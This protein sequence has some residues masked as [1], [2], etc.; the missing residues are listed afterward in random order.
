[1]SSDLERLLREAG[2]R[3]PEP[4]PGVTSRARTLALRAVRRRS[5][6]RPAAL[7]LAAALVG[8]GV[9]IGA[10]IAPSGTAAPGVVGLGFLPERGWSVLQNGGDGTPV[11]P[12]IAIAANVELSPDDDPDGLPL[13][14]LETLAPE[15]VVIVASFIARGEQEYY[16]RLFPETSLPLRAGHASRGIE[17]GADVRPGRPLGQYQLRASVNGHN[18][19]VNFYFGSD[20]PTAAMLA[21]AQ[22][23]LDL[24]VVRP[25][26]VRYR[27]TTEAAEE[28]VDRTYACTNT[29][30]AG[31]R[32][33]AIIGTRGF[34][35]GATWKWPASVE[36]LND[37]G[38]IT[39]LARVT[40]PNGV[41][42]APSVDTNWGFKA[43]AAAGSA[44]DGAVALWS[45]WARACAVTSVQVPLSTRGLIGSASDY[46][47]D[48]F[49]CRDVPRRV[50][51]R[52]RGVY[53]SQP[54]AFRPDAKTGYLHASG[55]VSEGAVAVRLESGRP[56][57]LGT[58]AASG[59]AEIFKARTCGRP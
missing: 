20:A 31:V 25:A 33:I 15:G 13:S 26:P 4:D 38:P 11:R 9:G 6:R 47:G 44:T 54:E 40:L 27:P 32:K 36:I 17:F 58:V 22:R 29:E 10:L 16:D 41:S 30:K 19:D 53:R 34:R 55:V 5:L 12:A 14:T 18:V 35:Q 7:L 51:V 46:F 2:R 50:Y 39:K 23:Q 8:A 21:D 56:L 48:S 28:I 3:L 52:V 57:L 1:M 24:M 45:K 43:A 42:Y 37:G 49:V 59:K